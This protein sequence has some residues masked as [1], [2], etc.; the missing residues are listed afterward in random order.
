MR[1]RIATI[2]IIVVLGM[3]AASCST[4]ETDETAAAEKAA[5]TQQTN[6]D[7]VFAQDI[8][9]LMATYTEDVEFFNDAIGTHW[10]SKTEYQANM[11]TIFEITDP[12]ATELIDNFVSDDGTRGVVVMH[13]VGEN[14]MGNPIDLTYVQLQE[15]EDGLI[16]KTMMYWENQ[17]VADQL[18]AGYPGS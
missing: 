6:I 15:F 14:G 7:A 11:T 8:D 2:V 1:N 18:N 13:W 10:R 9:A 3:L 16:D 12:D 5:A 17:D 4:G